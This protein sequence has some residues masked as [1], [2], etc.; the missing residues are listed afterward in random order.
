M[1]AARHPWPALGAL[2]VRDGAGGGSRARTVVVEACGYV[3]GFRVDR[4]TQVVAAK[5]EALEA[6]PDLTRE[7]GC[8]VVTALVRQSERP[9]ILVLDLD[10]LIDRAR[11]AEN[12]APASDGVAA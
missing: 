9:P 1:E 12:A 4:A 5:R 10:V 11:R 7:A 3:V 8:R 6:L 2:L